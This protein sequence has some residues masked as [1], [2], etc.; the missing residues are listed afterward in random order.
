MTARALSPPPAPA[1][2]G[3]TRGLSF[4]F[5]FAGGGTFWGLCRLLTGCSSFD[6][7]LRLSAQGD[8]RRVDMMVGDIYG[9]MDYAKVR[10]ARRRA[11]CLLGRGDDQK[12]TRRGF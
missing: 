5:A 9:G 10:P 2:F 8:N 3:E 12:N 11:G 1:F 6:E 7:M 4:L